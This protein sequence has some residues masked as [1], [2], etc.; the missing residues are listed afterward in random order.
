VPEIVNS[1][2][3]TILRG[4]ED[5]A[6]RHGFQVIV[7]N[8]D[9]TG[10][11]ERAYVEL[12][13]ASQ[14]AGVIVAAVGG[15]AASLEPLLQKR[16]P[17]VLI[18]RAI[19]GFEADIVKG[20]NVDG[21]AEL[22]RHLLSLGHRQIALVNGDL[23]TAVAREREAGYRRALAE[24]EVAVDDALISSGAWFID[25]AERR[26]SALLAAGRPITAILAANNF[27]AIGA[28]RALRQRGLRVPEEIALACFDDIEQA[29]EIEPFLT[30]M[31]QPAYTMGTLAMQ[32][33]LERMG[34]HERGGRREIVLAS[35]LVIRRSSGARDARPVQSGAVGNGRIAAAELVA[36]GD[37][38]SSSAEDVAVVAL[39]S[40]ERGKEVSAFGTMTS[41]AKDAAPNRSVE[42][43]ARDAAAT[44]RGDE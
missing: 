24:A 28:L 19:D 5:V 39:A 8:T 33:L 4:V 35:H 21:M 2:Y 11:K 31:A 29:A 12:M 7:G 18:D 22:A 27:M 9:E 34:G 38:G 36:N 41:I 26:T 20:D 30:V 1:F 25:D 13:I 17:T 23:A 40:V 37:D 3:T 32:M 16:V 43:A 15:T 42:G 6:N 10:A 44:P 14:V